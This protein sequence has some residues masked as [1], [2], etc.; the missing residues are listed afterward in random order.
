MGSLPRASPSPSTTP[1]SFPSVPGNS[2]CLRP[3]PVNACASIQ[4]FCM[5]LS[6]VSRTHRACRASHMGI[7]AFL[8]PAGASTAAASEAVVIFSLGG[9]TQIMN[10]R[11][12]PTKRAG[13]IGSASQFATTLRHGRDPHG[14]P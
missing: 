8:V 6:G 2:R 11:G 14:H 4:A 12:S 10:K 9:M 3:D 5:S 1:A 13:I 7:D